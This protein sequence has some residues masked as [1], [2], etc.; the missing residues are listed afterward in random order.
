LAVWGA[1]IIS[2]Q[3]GWG[4]VF[5]ILALCACLA[6]FSAYLMSRQF[7]KRVIES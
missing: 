3:L 5:Q 2:D 6:T 1:G 4:Q 7:R